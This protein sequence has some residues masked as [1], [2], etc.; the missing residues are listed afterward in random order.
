MV[1]RPG[2]FEARAAIIGEE[3]LRQLHETASADTAHLQRWLTENCFGDTY[4]RGGIVLV[5][6]EL[7]T[8]VLLVSHGGATRR[9]AATCRATFA[10]GRAV[11]CCWTRWASSYRSSATHGMLNGLA[12]V[13]ELAPAEGRCPAGVG[14][15]ETLYVPARGPVRAG[16][17]TCT[18]RRG[19]GRARERAARYPG[20]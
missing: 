15:R 11:R 12:A 13:N 16:E 3:R 17:R 14:P 7:L 9:Y 2:A 18:C 1:N 19:P 10:S 6:R 5:T 20:Q 8:V 4:T